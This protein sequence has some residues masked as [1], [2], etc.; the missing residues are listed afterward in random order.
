L[1][2]GLARLRDVAAITATIGTATIG[3]ATVARLRIGDVCKGKNS[4]AA[5]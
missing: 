2:N 4:C 1:L 5:G 3:T